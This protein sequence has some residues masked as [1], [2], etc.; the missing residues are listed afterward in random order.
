M[1]QIIET[2]EGA[3]HKLNVNFSG[4][5]DFTDCVVY[6]NCAPYG[7]CKCTHFEVVETTATGCELII[8]ALK[9]GVYKYQLF[10]K[11]NS[12]N[13]EFL[14]L[15][16]DITVKDRLCDCE[17]ES[18]TDSASTTVDATVSADTVEVNV[19][20]EKGPQGEPGPP[21]VVTPD[22]EE[23]ITVRVMAYTTV[24]LRPGMGVIIT[25]RIPG[26]AGF[27]YIDPA[28]PIHDMWYDMAVAYPFDYEPVMEEYTPVGQTAYNG[29]LF[30]IKRKH[31]PYL[32]D[33]FNG[34][35]EA[36][37]AIGANPFDITIL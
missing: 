29:W 24:T 3:L 13:Q 22:P 20:M 35:S 21:G 6:G 1:K 23:L 4:D 33:A 11:L 18:V 25:K 19:T 30:T 10:L 2:I 15:E 14:I 28:G 7:C 36:L 37:K 27:R 34:L 12:T 26:T 16:G 5:V 9:C 17:K 8:P 32:E 31:L